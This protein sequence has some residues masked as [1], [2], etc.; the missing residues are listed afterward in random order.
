MSSGRVI[1]GGTA[2]KG[3]ADL[4]AGIRG[5]GD[6]TSGSRQEESGMAWDTRSRVGGGAL[7]GDRQM[8]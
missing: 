5:L 4:G 6:Y 7:K 1:L 2:R 3:R 8:L